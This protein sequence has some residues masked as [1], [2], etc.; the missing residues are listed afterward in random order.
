M[1]EAILATWEP[2][3]LMG[4]KVDASGYA[5]GGVLLQQLEDGLW[6]PITFCLESMNE[7][8]RN[9]EIYDRE[10]LVIIQGLEDWC[11]YIEGLPQ[12]FKII[13][14][15]QSLRYWCTTQHLTCRQAL[16]ALWLSRFEFTLTHKPA[17]INTQADPLSQIPAYQVMDTDNNQNQ[18]VL[19]PELFATLAASSTE[20]CPLKAAVQ[21]ATQRDSEVVEALRTLREKGPRHLVNSILEWEECDGLVYYCRKVY[22]PLDEDLC[23]RILKQCHNGITAGHS[24]RHGTLKLILRH[25]LVAQNELIHDQVRVQM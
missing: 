8:K 17:K 10:M 23:C 22:V 5:T 13:T 14:D 15:H 12:L 21:E 11:P 24:G 19:K 9:Y 6:H 18:I 20:L 7:A 2:N 16:W 25:L 3:G 4:V 1:K